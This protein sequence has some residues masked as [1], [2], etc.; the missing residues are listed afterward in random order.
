V[1]DADRVVG[2]Q[3]VERGIRLRDAEGGC[4]LG[5]SFGAAAE[6]P[7]HV[8]PDAPEGFDMD[9]ADEPGADDGG[10]DRGGHPRRIPL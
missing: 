7:A 1:D 3:R 2:E 4:S 5:A 10:A 9:G 6:D 8:H